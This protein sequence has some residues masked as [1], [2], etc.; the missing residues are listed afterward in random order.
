MIFKLSFLKFYEMGVDDANKNITKISEIAKSRAIKKALKQA[1]LEGEMD[2]IS[3]YYDLWS[4]QYE[5]LD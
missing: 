3:N 1:Y 4:T 5:C 2:A